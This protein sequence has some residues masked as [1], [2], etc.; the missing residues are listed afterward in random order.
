MNDYK[1]G[2]SAA[3][4]GM[5][6]DRDEEPSDEQVVF[7]AATTELFEVIE[8]YG[9]GH[10]MRQLTLDKLGERDDDLAQL[11]RQ[12]TEMGMRRLQRDLVRAAQDLDEAGRSLLA[13]RRRKGVGLQ[14]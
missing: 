12:A 10:R 7:A 14:S 9:I 2:W 1:N 5:L 6:L 13:A 4:E 3:L 11:S 8:A